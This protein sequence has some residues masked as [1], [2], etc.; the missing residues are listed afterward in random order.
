MNLRASE[1]LPDRMAIMPSMVSVGLFIFVSSCLF[2]SE[3]IDVTA[4]ATSPRARYS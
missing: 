4:F 1:W 2:M 3:S